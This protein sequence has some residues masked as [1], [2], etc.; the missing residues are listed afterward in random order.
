MTAL[1]FYVESGLGIALVPKVFV[2]PDAKET[3]AKNIGGSLISMTMGILCKES[4]YPFQ[5]AS[6]RLYN[7][8]KQ[9]WGTYP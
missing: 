4:A 9:E 8:L 2:D 6:R 1:K 7:F 5:Q 3:A